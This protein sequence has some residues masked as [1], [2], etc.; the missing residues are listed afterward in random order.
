MV[1]TTVDGVHVVL[2][3]PTKEANK[4]QYMHHSI[5]YSLPP[6]VIAV[7]NH[8]CLVFVSTTEVGIDELFIKLMFILCFQ[9]ITSC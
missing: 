1:Y 6:L 7:L 2:K 5:I 4:K 3:L 8:S 9:I